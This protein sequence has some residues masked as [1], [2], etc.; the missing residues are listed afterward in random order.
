MLYPDLLMLAILL[1]GIC[2]T[3]RAQQSSQ[4]LHNHVH[5]E[6]TTGQAPLVASL[7]PQQRMN[8]SIVLPLR[9][10]AELASLLHRLYD[11]SSPDFRQFLSVD[12]FTERFGPT[13]QDY[14][15]AVAF[16][17]ANGFTITGTPVNRLVVP[18]SGTAD[19]IN[20]AFHV[21]MNVYRHP[22]EDRTFY[23]PDREPWDRTAP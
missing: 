9:N 2:S 1:A 21:R 23:S 17:R 7:P 10:Q 8:L 15:A 19:Q 22:T 14:Q 12:Q 11:P 18:I 16:A 13:V 5:R 6:V 4:A 20:S 3:G